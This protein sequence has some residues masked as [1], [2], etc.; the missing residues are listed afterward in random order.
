MFAGLPPATFSFMTTT[1][2]VPRGGAPEWAGVLRDLQ[3]PFG[4]RVLVA[5]DRADRVAD[6]YQA[7]GAPPVAY[8]RPGL[9]FLAKEPPDTDLEV[10][11]PAATGLGDGTVDLVVLRHAWGG[12]ADLP[13]TVAEA[14]RVL[15]A[16][17]TLVLFEPDL[18]RLL[19]S[20]VQRYPSQI[21]YR[22]HPNVAA[23]LRSSL[24]A[25]GELAAEAVRTGFIRLTG[26]EVEDT[27][28]SFERSDY[29]Q[30][31]RDR[32]WLGFAL[33]SD[34]EIAGVLEA[35]AGLLPLLA[36][37]GPVVER[38]PWRVLRGVKPA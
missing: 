38:E 6:A 20:Q 29:L 3:V 21:L 32:G 11:L 15:A 2:R 22:L 13:A 35:V 17:G 19:S 33:L 31:L 37:I 26:T 4:D 14:R 34:A 24:V 36:P 18:T 25:P 30:F 7:A 23:D 12:P 9:A 8:A 16:G 10:A 28:G 5:G 27:I 1:A